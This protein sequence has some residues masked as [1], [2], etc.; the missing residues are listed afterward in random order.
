[1]TVKKDR[2]KNLLSG[3]PVEPE[4]EITEVNMNENISPI[5]NIKVV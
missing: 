2:L 1:M 3:N 4:T 5:A